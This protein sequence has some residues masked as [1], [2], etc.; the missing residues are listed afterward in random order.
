MK[1]A[2]LKTSVVHGKCTFQ[3]N[4]YCHREGALNLKTVEFQLQLGLKKYQ[5]YWKIYLFVLF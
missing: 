3:K 2:S 1:G 4:H 5:K